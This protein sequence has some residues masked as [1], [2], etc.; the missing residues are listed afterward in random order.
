MILTKEYYKTAFKKALDAFAGKLRSYVSTETG[1][2]IK[3]A[4]T[5]K[6]TNLKDFLIFK[7]RT[8]L[9]DNIKKEY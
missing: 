1:E 4:K 2:M 6:I 7:G 3:D 9:L 5:I 8:D